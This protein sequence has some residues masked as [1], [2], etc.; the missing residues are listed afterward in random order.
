MKKTLII[1]ATLLSFGSAVAVTAAPAFAQEFTTNGEAAD[2]RTD[3][4]AGNHAG[5]CVVTDTN[6]C[7]PASN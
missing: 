6:K 2:T 5:D 7:A 1:A 4:A 3:T